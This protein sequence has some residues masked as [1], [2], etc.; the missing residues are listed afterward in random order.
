MDDRELAEFERDL[1]A[2]RP[3]SP[4]PLPLRRGKVV[5]TRLLTMLSAAAVALLGM[6][7]VKRLERP[8]RPSTDRPPSVL[9]TLPDAHGAPDVSLATLRRAAVDDNSL[10]E[11]LDAAAPRLLRA[12][13]GE[14]MR[15]R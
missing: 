10:T 6:Q 13:G 7:I 3:R 5:L 2:F 4:R 1:R 14:E 9:Y 11:F 12:V 8:N 15:I